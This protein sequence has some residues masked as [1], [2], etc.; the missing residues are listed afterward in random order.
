MKEYVPGPLYRKLLTESTL[1]SAD[2][3]DPNY[4]IK[5]RDNIGIHQ[6]GKYNRVKPMMPNV[7]YEKQ[8]REI[9]LQ[10]AH[11]LIDYPPTL[12]RFPF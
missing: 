9:A 3:D 10:N 4:E 2:E 6:Q 8:R 12:N 1:I 7:D 5:N 11:R